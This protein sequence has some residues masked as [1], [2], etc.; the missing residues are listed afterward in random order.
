[1]VGDVRNPIVAADVVEAE[2]V[3]AIQSEP[4]V[5]KVVATA[6]M[7]VFVVDEAVVHADVEA[8]VGGCSEGVPLQSCMRRGL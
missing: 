6:Q 1:M 8:L 3:E 4:N 5:A 2:D 7:M